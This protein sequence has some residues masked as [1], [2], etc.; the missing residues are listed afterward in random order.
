MPRPTP[1]QTLEQAIRDEPADA[2]NYL[3][4][5][6]IYGD[7]GQFEQ[8]ERVLRRGA[9]HCAQQSALQDALSRIAELRGRAASQRA[10][11]RS[12][13]ETRSW[14]KLRLEL[15]L[16]ISLFVLVVQLG[17][18][19]WSNILTAVG[20]NARLLLII[21]NL[22]VLSLLIWHRQRGAL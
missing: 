22:A 9:R 6:D 11:T 1:E 4:L 19:W 10:Q 20:H 2:S 16:V 12:S 17:P 14:F 21:L 18:N 15:C 7:H 8:A 13:P 5:A 3:R